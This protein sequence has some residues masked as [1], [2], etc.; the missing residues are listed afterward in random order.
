MP[1]ER[2]R[3]M[4]NFNPQGHIVFSDGLASFEYRYRWHDISPSKDILP[5]TL[6]VHGC[7]STIA[8]S[9]YKHTNRQILKVLVDLC[10][11]TM[12]ETG[13]LCSSEI[14]YT[15]ASIL[16]CKYFAT[17]QLGL[18]WQYSM[19]SDPRESTHPKKAGAQNHVEFLLPSLEVVGCRGRGSH[20]P[21]YGRCC[22]DEADLLLARLL[23]YPQSYWASQCLRPRTFSLAMPLLDWK[24][25]RMP[26]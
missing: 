8:I 12:I 19:G 7:V 4:Y 15:L 25:R 3:K 23:L 1:L 16:V 2:R 18:K 14:S 22:L 11:A 24:R 10:G 9:G 20:L 21:F 17:S 13:G 5:G 6:T 26:W